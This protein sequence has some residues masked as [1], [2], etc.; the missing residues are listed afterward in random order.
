MSDVF[1]TMITVVLALI[2]M[3]IFPLAFIGNQNEII[4]EKLGLQQNS[5]V[6]HV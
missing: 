1:I 5:I 6:M 2:L 3:F 4:T